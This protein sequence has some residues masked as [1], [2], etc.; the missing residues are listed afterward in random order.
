MASQG[1]SWTL[2]VAVVLG[3]LHAARAIAAGLLHLSPLLLAALA[4]A[5]AAATFGLSTSA[6]AFV[7]GSAT[8][9]IASYACGLRRGLRSPSDDALVA[10]T[11]ATCRRRPTSAKAASAPQLSAQPAVAAEA[12]LKGV[13]TT[14]AALLGISRC[15]AVSPT[16]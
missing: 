6:L 7:D 11:A 3:A 13:Q 12:E 8:K 10:A 2:F 16:C 5:T 1:L 15:A 9:R 14:R 4:A